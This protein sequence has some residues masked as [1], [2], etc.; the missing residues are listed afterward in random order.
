MAETANDDRDFW[1]RVRDHSGKVTWAY[2]ATVDGT[3]PKVRVVHPG[4]E[5]DKLWVATGRT[6]A[7]ARH[8]EKNPK[9]ELFYQVGPEFIHITVTGEACFIDDPKEKQRVWNSGIFDYDLK[10]FWPAGH[11]APEFG[12]ML[13]K[14]RRV[15]MTSMI[16]MMQGKKPEVRRPN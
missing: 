14:P 10:Q 13:V 11:A 12:L 9:V 16:E 4:W 8:V 7:K 6:S 1:Q 2:L 5:G 3:Q 15:E